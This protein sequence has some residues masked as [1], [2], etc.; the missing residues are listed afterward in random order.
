LLTE[1]SAAEFQKGDFMQKKLLYISFVA[2]FVFLGCSGANEKKLKSGDVRK[3]VQESLTDPGM[4][5]Q[6][7]L[8]TIQSQ[9]NGQCRY[10]VNRTKQVLG[11]DANQTEVV[12]ENKYSLIQANPG[13]TRLPDDTKT[14]KYSHALARAQYLNKIDFLTTEALFTNIVPSAR[15]AQ[16]QTLKEERTKNLKVI[17]VTIQ[18]IDD[19]DGRFYRYQAAISLESYFVGIFEVRIQDLSNQL[20][21]YTT[22]NRVHLNNPVVNYP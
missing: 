13:C 21:E 17:T 1:K 12:I 8:E 11:V 22:L 10:R 14:E 6:M 19:R 5:D 20:I 4:F 15:S 7:E 18:Y 2:V 3:L 9:N 16:I